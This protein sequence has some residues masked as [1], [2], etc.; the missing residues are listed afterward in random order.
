MSDKLLQNDIRKL[1]GGDSEIFEK[2]FHAYYENLVFYARE[3]IIIEDQA[4]EIV[5]EAFVKLWERR[6]SL[7]TDSNI[8]AYL[9]IITRNLCLN[10]LDHIRVGQ[11]F[12]RMKER[13]VLT[14]ELHSIA[15]QD[16]TSE[17]LI[18]GELES[19]IEKLIEELPEQNR[20]VFKMHRFDDMKYSEIAQK[21]NISVKAVEGH[22]SRALKYL[23]DH[24]GEYLYTF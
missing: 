1:I 12:K 4:R 17:Y 10:Y 15:M 23:R 18:A 24:L 3:Y 19:K 16:P 22:I 20:K 6:Q 7:S 8:R 13:D 9:Y 2:I 5:Q 11:R 14:L 21:L